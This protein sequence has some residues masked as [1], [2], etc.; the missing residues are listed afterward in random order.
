ME[1]AVDKE[2]KPILAEQEVRSII[3]KNQF[4]V[5]DVKKRPDRYLNDVIFANV[6]PQLSTEKKL[7][8]TLQHLN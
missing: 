1:T 5:A 7:K 3:I 2:V 8:N 4:E 6:E